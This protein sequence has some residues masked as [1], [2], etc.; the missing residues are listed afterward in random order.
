MQTIIQLDT[1]LTDHY[2]PYIGGTANP[3]YTRT[4]TDSGYYYMQIVSLNYGGPGYFKV[5]MEAPNA[6][7]DVPANPTWQIDYIS[8]KQGDLKP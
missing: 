5:M 2:N 1:Y 7:L 6:T 4:F 8:I 3:K